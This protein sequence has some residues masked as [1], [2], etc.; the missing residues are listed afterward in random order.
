MQ[1]AASAARRLVLAGLALDGGPP[2][3]LP[4]VQAAAWRSTAVRSGLAFDPQRPGARRPS[5]GGLAFD[6]QRPRA[7]LLLSYAVTTVRP[8]QTTASG[9]LSRTLPS[10][11]ARW[12]ATFFRAG[13]R[14]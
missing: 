11:T 13:H 3:P 5:S 8:S 4:R 2:H 12:S 1:A 7:F 10:S 6:P 9:T 14:C